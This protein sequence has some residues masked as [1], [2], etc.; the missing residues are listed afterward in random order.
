MHYT[1]L[2][3]E[4]QIAMLETRIASFERDHF[5]HEVNKTAISMQP[6]SEAKTEA[7]VNADAAQAVIESAIMCC[8]EQLNALKNPPVA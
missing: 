1:Y 6:E 5:G 8:T 2:T 4:Q 7:L 3:N